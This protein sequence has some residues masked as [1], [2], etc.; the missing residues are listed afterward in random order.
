MNLLKQ[1]NIRIIDRATDWEDAVRQ[2]V[3]PLEEGGYVTPRYK[4]AIIEKAKE[5]GPYFI[6]T[7]DIVLPHARPE[8]GVNESQ[9]AVTLFREPVSFN[10]DYSS[11]RL[12]IA[13]AAND[14]EAHLETLASIMGLFQDE[15]RTQEV[16]HAEST[17][18]LI[19]FFE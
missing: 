8:E 19:R 15:S 9:L 16:L 5:L 7:P 13:L 2:S 11:V 3:A 17:D 18:I 4:E 10:D 6:L 14:G 1:E 12:F